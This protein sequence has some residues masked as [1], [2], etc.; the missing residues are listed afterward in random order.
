[1][2]RLL[3][4]AM[5]GNEAMAASLAAQLNVDVGVLDCHTFPDG[6]TLPRFTVGLA[7]R[8]VALVCTLAR[9]NDK[10]LPLLFAAAAARDLGAAH[11]GLVAPYL[12]YMRQDRRFH[13]GEAITS[14]HF[15][16][17]LSRTFDWLVTVD[18]HLH[19]YKS[20]SDIYDIPA[21]AEHAGCVG[22]GCCGRD[23]SCD[24]TRVQFRIAWTGNA[25]KGGTAGAFPKAGYRIFGD[26]VPI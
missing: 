9:P 16:A 11:V 19:R 25:G 20:L 10:I 12:S 22:W 8:H 13:A 4:L 2:K 18:P 5:P 7:D 6:E 17:L 3:L 23:A 1:M 24:G 14:R 15:A 26:L 21:I